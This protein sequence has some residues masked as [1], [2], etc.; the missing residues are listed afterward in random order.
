MILD[1]G[2]YDLCIELELFSL[3]SSIPKMTMQYQ[4]NGK[5][6]TGE[7][8]K[9]WKDSIREDCQKLLKC[10]N[11]EERARDREDWRQRIKKAMAH[12]GL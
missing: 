3:Y 5:R 10:G 8:K 1:L 9:R 11:W 4:I 12:I 7:P 2:M 6:P